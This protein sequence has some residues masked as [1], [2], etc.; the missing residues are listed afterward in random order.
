MITPETIT[1]ILAKYGLTE[2]YKGLWGIVLFEALCSD[3]QKLQRPEIELEEPCS[4]EESKRRARA[5]AVFLKR[6]QPEKVGT[7]V[8]NG[9]SDG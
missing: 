6:S 1:L 3:L 4:P 8:V 2:K 7:D 5:A 9:D